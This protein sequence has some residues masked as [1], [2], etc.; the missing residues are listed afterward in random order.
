MMLLPGLRERPEV[1]LR[2]RLTKIQTVLEQFHEVVFI[3]LNLRLNL[4]WV[5]VRPRPG[6]ILAIACALQ[7]GMPEALLVA[8]H[9][10]C[11]D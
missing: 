4:L 11:A 10:S 7:A 8:Q 5:S 1:Q 6:I 3:D 2:E 9:A